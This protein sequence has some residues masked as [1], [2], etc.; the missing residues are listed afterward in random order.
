MTRNDQQPSCP[1]TANIVLWNALNEGIPEKIQYHEKKRTL[2]A[3]NCE[4][5]KLMRYFKNIV[6]IKKYKIMDG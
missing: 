5:V 2:L 3:R 6:Y 4:V 1:N